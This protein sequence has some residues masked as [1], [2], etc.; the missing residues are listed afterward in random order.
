V[1]F[2]RVSQGRTGARP[3]QFR[4]ELLQ[5]APS[6]LRV[7]VG[8]FLPRGCC[9]RAEHLHA[10]WAGRFPGRACP[11]PISCLL[12]LQGQQLR[13]LIYCVDLHKA[14]GCVQMG[15]LLWWLQLQPPQKGG[16]WGIVPCC[17]V[18]H[19]SCS[20]RSPCELGTGQIVC[21]C[22]H[23]PKFGSHSSQHSCHTKTRWHASAA[24]SPCVLGRKPGQCRY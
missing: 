4:E 18:W 14:C 15:R 16:A 17:V 13:A 23:L 20:A 19:H 22:W 3:D 24:R 8:Q 7:E 1:C 11:V 5:G 21:R 6:T 2:W 9:R 10:Q 12:T